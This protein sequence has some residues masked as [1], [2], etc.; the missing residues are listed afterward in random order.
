MF[1][2]EKSENYGKQGQ[3]D[4]RN[5]GNEIAAQL[6]AEKYPDIRIYLTPAVTAA[7][8]AALWPHCREL[9]ENFR[10]L[11]AGGPQFIE[12][13]ASFDDGR[14][15]GVAN[16]PGLCAFHFKDGRFSRL[17]F[18]TTRPNAGDDVQASLHLGRIDETV[19]APISTNRDSAR[20]RR[21]A[22]AYESV[23]TSLPLLMMMTC[24][25]VCSTSGR[26]WVLK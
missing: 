22:I 20:A 26:M 16:G 14:E 23:A 9:Q 8:S 10:G 5:G 21:S 25:Q 15:R 18:R 11:T 2:K 3:Q 13:P 7:S 6:F 19:A 12:V 24:S 17:F 1:Q 4:I